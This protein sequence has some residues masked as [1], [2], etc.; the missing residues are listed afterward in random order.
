MPSTGFFLLLENV[1]L[2]LFLT[3]PQQQMNLCAGSFILS[4]QP[5]EAAN[6]YGSAEAGQNLSGPLWL[7]RCRGA[8]YRALTLH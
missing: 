2:F 1:S 4:V 8:N 5:V 7:C 3:Q 6:L